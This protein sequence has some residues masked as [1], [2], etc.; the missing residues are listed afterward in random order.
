VRTDASRGYQLVG[1]KHADHAL[2]WF[3]YHSTEHSVA[4]TGRSQHAFPGKQ[5]AIGSKKQR[6]SALTCVLVKGDPV[7]QF[8]MSWLLVGG[9]FRIHAINGVGRRKGRII[10]V[11]VI[12]TGEHFHGSARRMERLVLALQGS[13]DDRRRDRAWTPEPNS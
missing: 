9:R 7:A 2:V 6:Y 13:D 8:L 4:A 10:E 5:Q 11:E 12:A 3:G 1:E